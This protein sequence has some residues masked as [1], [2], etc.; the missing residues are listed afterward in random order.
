M[1]VRCVSMVSIKTL[2]TTALNVDSKDVLHVIVH[3]TASFALKVSLRQ[4][5]LTLT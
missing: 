3:M 2:T 5:T 4:K 1:F